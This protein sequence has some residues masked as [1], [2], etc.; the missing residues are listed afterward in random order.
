MIILKLLSLKYTIF[1]ETYNCI[2]SF[3]NADIL[4]DAR[5]EMLTTISVVLIGFN[6]TIMSVFGSSYSQAVV[7]ISDK[8]LCENFIKYAKKFLIVTFIFFII[9]IFYDVMKWEFFVFIYIS[10][11]ISVIMEFIRFSAIVLKM[12]DVNISDASSAVEKQ[13]KYQD[14][15][16]KLLRQI[17]DDLQ[18]ENTKSNTEY[19]N[20]MKEAMDIQRKNC[21]KI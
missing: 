4:T 16:I 5:V 2:F 11:F 21:E 6:V 9:T 14:E 7:E 3:L 17:K 20:E 8:N 19:F 15:T 1:M 10:V 18:V 12:Y 13:K